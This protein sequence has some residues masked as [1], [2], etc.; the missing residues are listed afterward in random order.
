MYNNQRRNLV[1]SSLHVPNTKIH[2]RSVKP[3]RKIEST[4]LHQEIAASAQLRRAT[5]YPGLDDST[6]FT[7]SLFRFWY[8]IE[9]NTKSG[10]ESE[11]KITGHF[12]P[13]SCHLMAAVLVTIFILNQLLNN[14]GD[15]L[16]SPRWDTIAV[17]ARHL[18]SESALTRVSRYATA[19]L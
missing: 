4:T 18:I 17:I 15:N 13:N 9:L 1:I 19:Q 10:G 11:C 16:S 12:F 2:S 14:G 5:C 8:C 7:R 6:R 3:K